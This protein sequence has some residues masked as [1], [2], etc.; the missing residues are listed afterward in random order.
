MLPWTTLTLLPLVVIF[1]PLFLRFLSRIVGS[2]I[3]IVLITQK[4]L[5]LL[6]AGDI[7]MARTAIQSDLS[8]NNVGKLSYSV[9][10]PYQ[11]LRNIE[12][13]S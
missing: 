8:K 2:L 12:L 1:L 5:V 7:V 11:I 10:G 9:R 13:G 3:P 4:N 6:K